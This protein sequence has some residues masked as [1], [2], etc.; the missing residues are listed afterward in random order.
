MTTRATTRVFVACFLW[1]LASSTAAR[2]QECSGAITADE[3]TRAEDARYAAQT[4]ND[5]AAMD[6]L[7]GADLV[8]VH[9]S[10]VVDSKASYLEVMRSGSTRYRS[11]RRREVT[12]RTYGCVAV[13]T[14]TADFEITSR[15][16]DL[17]LQLRF[18][19][20]WVKR[21]IGVEFVSWNSTRIA[22][23]TQ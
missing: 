21:P 20:A 9:S 16:Q 11:M 19:S 12:V 15:G 8:Y 23:P 4:S 13:L 7:F 5:F 3:A 17:S 14:G 6:R 22:P 1:G 10:G 2:A 18:L